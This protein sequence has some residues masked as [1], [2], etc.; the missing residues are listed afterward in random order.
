MRDD[1][2]GQTRS[3]QGKP[4]LAIVIREALWL[5]D[6]MTLQEKTIAF[7]GAGNMAEA[8][9]RGLLTSQSLPASR[10]IVTDV[11][12]ERLDYFVKSFGVTA[13]LDNAP[14]VAKSDTIVL[15]VKPQQAG[16]VLA[17]LKA[18]FGPT[19]ILISIAAGVTTARIERELGGAPRV[20]RVMPNT[21]A[22]VGAGA[23]GFCP[24]KFA[25]E[26]D[27]A[28][29]AAILGAVGI[30]VRV[31]ETMMDAVTAVSGSGPA[32]IFLVAEAMIRAGTEA[33]LSE[34]VARKLTVQTIF[35]A[36]ALMAA[37]GELPV[38]LRRK[39]TSPGGT[40]EAALKVMTERQLVEVF[41]AAVAAAK[42]RGQELARA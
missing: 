19:K 1:A 12:Q 14:A 41:V 15:A 4:G 7:L 11:R 39:V 3:A 34:E 23:A 26:E 32:Y 29:T 40:T 20:V 33:G 9:V 21:P 42:Q 27:L 5:N 18:E 24:G 6:G 10:I 28:T 37:S 36:G 13:H 25:T 16:A 8:L 38:E 17:G 31:D 35:G 30:A 22:L 2:T